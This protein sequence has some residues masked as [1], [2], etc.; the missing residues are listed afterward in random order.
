MNLD[1]NQII[2]LISKK[3]K[4]LSKAKRI[5]SKLR[6]FTEALEHEELQEETSFQ[7]IEKRL[8]DKISKP[9]TQKVLKFVETPLPV[10][11]VCDSILQDLYKVFNAGNAFFS[12]KSQK[13][14]GGDKLD[15]LL[16]KLNIVNWVEKYGKEVL[17][18]K[19]NLVVVVDIDENG[20]PFL[21]PI[22]T[23]RIVN[24]GYI[25]NTDEF[26]YFIFK[27]S[28]GEN[29]DRVGI[30]TTTH[31][32]TAI[33]HDGGEYKV[34][35]TSYEHNLGYC[36]AKSFWSD[37]LNDDNEFLRKT[38]FITSLGLLTKYV[39]F[40]LFKYYSDH[41]T[42]FPVI[43]MVR[44]NCGNPE[45]KNGTIIQSVQEVIHGE[46]IQRTVTKEC[47]R[48][49]ELNNIGI[50]AKILLEPQ[51]SKDE[52]TAAG[53][54]KQHSNDIAGLQYLGELVKTDKED[55]KAAIVGVDASATKEALNEKQVQSSF[56]SKEN[57]LT[58]MKTNL[59]KI[60][61]WIVQT[62]SKLYQPKLEVEISASFG[63]EF[64][65]VSEEDLQDRLDRAIESGKPKS[66]IQDIYFQL[67][68][69]KY[70]NNPS[71]V[72]KHKLINALDPLAFNNIDVKF[73]KLEAGVISKETFLLSENLL[74]LIVQFEAENS[75]IAD[76]GIEFNFG[77]RVQKIKE[78]LLTYISKDEKDTSEPLPTSIGFNKS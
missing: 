56:Q 55:I 36:P 50:G 61:I 18:T 38:P 31:Y 75:N 16:N 54:Y 78:I 62:V 76:F 59:E 20:K 26:E 13:A 29:W 67:L 25:P 71:E 57:V 23:N 2:S 77:E 14:R 65:L 32:I 17:K 22:N 41:T 4:Q 64:Y 27:H 12:V 69:S 60:Y 21:L 34:E 70:K 73:R 28:D 40:D 37:R 19:P 45:C 52:P 6:I 8:Y 58:S 43:E 51:M 63:T 24:F 15:I 30:Y 48:C 74:S 53:L 44:A 42:P 5:E 47:T 11:S 68:D 66:L 9:K 72:L 1:V 49:S 33:R 46:S 7:D 39:S 10:V 35:D 3:P